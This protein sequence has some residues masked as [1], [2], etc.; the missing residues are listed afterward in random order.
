V[1]QRKRSSYQAFRKNAGFTPAEQ[2]RVY[3]SISVGRLDVGRTGR[4]TEW[5][6]H[7]TKLPHAKLV[8]CT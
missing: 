7:R 4:V 5:L 6:M 1:P 2:E 8:F 3:L